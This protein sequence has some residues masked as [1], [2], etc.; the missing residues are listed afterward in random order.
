MSDTRYDAVVLGGGMA[1]LGTAERL[2]ASGK[3]VV[4]VEAA[5]TVGG[6]ARS[7]TVGGEPI[8]PYYHHIFP[9]DHETRELIDR[10]GMTDRLEWRHAPMAVMH[11]GVAVPFDSP[12]DVLSFPA[13]SFPQ[14]FR[15]GFGSAY[16]LV[17]RDRRRMD[18]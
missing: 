9:Q 12:L 10:L 6:L 13:I 8:E 1:G 16:Q 4:L 18:A 3:R 2:H 17:R 5:Q 14:R 7:I 11:H 15:L